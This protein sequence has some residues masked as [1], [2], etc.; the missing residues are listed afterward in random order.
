MLYVIA[1]TAKHRPTLMH[2]VGQSGQSNYTECG[3]FISGWSRAY[4]DA[5][6]PQV[7]CLRC[8]GVTRAH[9]DR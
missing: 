5:P 7:L 1:R 6:I 3:V 8:Q 2:I 4:F 9:A